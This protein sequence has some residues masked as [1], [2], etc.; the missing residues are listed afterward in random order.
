LSRHDDLVTRLARIE[1]GLA[2]SR[3]AEYV[4]QRIDLLKIAKAT[5]GELEY[6]E[7]AM[8]IFGLVQVASFLA[9]DQVEG[10]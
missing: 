9:G 3:F 2:E 8:D 7:D 5:I 4:A 6:D 1:T 10:S